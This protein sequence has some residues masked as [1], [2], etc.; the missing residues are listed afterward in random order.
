MSRTRSDQVQRGRSQVI[1]LQ[2]IFNQDSY[3]HNDRNTIFLFDCRTT[4]EGYHAASVGESIIQS[5]AVKYRAYNKFIFKCVACKADNIIAKPV[6]KIDNHYVPVLEA[7][8]NKDCS[9]PPYKQLSSIR[10]QLTLFIR[11][12][13][14]DYYDNWMYCDEPNCNQSTRTFVHVTDLNNRPVCVTCKQGH[15][16]KSYTE[17][18]LYK[19]LN[20]LQYM[21][22]LP[23]V[24]PSRKLST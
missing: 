5:N 11:K 21:F 22:T 10:N 8:A 14:R 3:L 9:M 12:N 24:E 23:R 2:H 16:L 20:Y 18:D 6:H 13:I 17:G 19:Q 4:S 15:M 1:K 7:C